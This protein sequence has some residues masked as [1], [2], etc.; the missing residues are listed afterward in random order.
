MP[1]RC[2][3]GHEKASSTVL[4]PRVLV[5]GALLWKLDEVRPS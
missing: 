4:R 3:G 5:N 1:A 2:S